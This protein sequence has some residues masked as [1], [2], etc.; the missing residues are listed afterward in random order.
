MVHKSAAAHES[1]QKDAG[2]GGRTKN[3]DPASPEV[4]TG[5]HGD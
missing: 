5:D 4:L 1:D 3:T 2:V